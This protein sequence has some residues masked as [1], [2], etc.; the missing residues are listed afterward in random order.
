MDDI[1]IM[2]SPEREHSF[3]LSDIPV[4]GRPAGKASRLY[5]ISTVS[6]DD[7][8]VR[9]QLRKLGQPATLFGEG[10]ADRRNRLKELLATLGTEGIEKKDEE[11]EAVKPEKETES[12]WYHEGPESLHNARLWLACYS[13]PRA[14]ERLARAKEELSVPESTRT[15]KRYFKN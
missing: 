14:K 13:L 12:T 10:P 8:E 15:A 7:G 9:K 5:G 4:E 3:S 1:P 2:R 6:T 11:R